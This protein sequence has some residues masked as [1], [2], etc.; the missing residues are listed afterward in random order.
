MQGNNRGL[1]ILFG[2]LILIALLG[3]MF[4]GGWGMMGPG[5]MGPGMMWGPG[6]NGATGWGIWMLLG[7]LS[8]LAFWGAVILGIV[9]VVRAVAGSGG[10]AE[11]SAIEILRRRY[12]AG[13]ITREEYEAMRA[14]LEDTGS[15]AK[16]RE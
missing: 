4:A 16:T 1:W 3:P 6:G 9:L 7:W 12:A 13:E 15:R 8:M 10:R 2:V 14:D 11:D 5:M